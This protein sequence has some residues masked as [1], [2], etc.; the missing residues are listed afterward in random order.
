VVEAELR[1]EDLEFTARHL[2][3]LAAGAEQAQFIDRLIE[4]ARL[5]GHEAGEIEGIGGHGSRTY[6]A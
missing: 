1:L 6:L 5:C 4:N 2:A 3:H